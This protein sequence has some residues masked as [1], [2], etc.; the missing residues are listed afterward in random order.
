MAEIW[1]KAN[2]PNKLKHKPQPQAS[3]CVKKAVAID[4][5]LSN[6]IMWLYIDNSTVSIK[7]CVSLLSF[8]MRWGA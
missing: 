8:T 3:V 4:I 1:E 2:I 7:L 5:N 6:S